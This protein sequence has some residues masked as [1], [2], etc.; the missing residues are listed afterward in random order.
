MMSSVFSGRMSDLITYLL[1]EIQ[2]GQWGRSLSY[3]SVRLWQC[4]WQADV[5]IRF[6][7]TTA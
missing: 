4:G 5:V 6:G 2:V 1:I 3:S 7:L